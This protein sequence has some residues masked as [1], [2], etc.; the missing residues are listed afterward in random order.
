MEHRVEWT[1][2][3]PVWPALIGA[4][5]ASATRAFNRPSLFRFASDTFMDDFVAMLDVDPMRLGEFAARPETWRGP[6]AAVAP[7]PAAPSFARALQRKRLIALRRT[8]PP[9]AAP[10]T[11]QSPVLKLYQPAHQR[12][13]LVSANLVCQLPGIPDRAIDPGKDER[14]TFVVRRLLP[15]PGVT[16]PT[17]D[18]ATAD[19]YAFV[20]DGADRSWRATAPGSGAALVAGEE[21]LPLSP[22]TYRG[23]DGRRRRVLSGLVPVSRRDAYLGAAARDQRAA[24]VAATAAAPDPRMTLLQQQVT[25]PWRQVVGRAS[26]IE[27]M[28]RNRVSKLWLLNYSHPDT[29]IGTHPWGIFLEE[30]GGLVPLYIYKPTKPDDPYVA[31]FTAAVDLDQDGTDELVVEASYRIGTAYKVISSSGGKYQE[32]FTSYYRGPAS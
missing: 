13:Y 14:A 1:A 28:M 7:T 32:A 3:S 12:Y 9:A 20:I 15:K 22:A 2:A 30:N 23:D 18:P 11:T 10:P 8:P 19:E 21:Q 24:S 29:T 25:E 4:A 27:A 5:D 16:R 6:S 26:A 17:T 31:Y